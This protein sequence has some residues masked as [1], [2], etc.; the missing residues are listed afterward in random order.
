[1]AAQGVRGGRLVV[2]GGELLVALQ[3]LMYIV[4]V[5]RAGVG[6]LD[7]QPVFRENALEGLTFLQDFVK[8]L[9]KGVV[10]LHADV[11]A[12]SQNTSQLSHDLV[13]GMERIPYIGLGIVDKQVVHDA[14]IAGEV[15]K[16]RGDGRHLVRVGGVGRVED[17]GR[18]FH[19]VFIIRDIAD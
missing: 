6:D 8:V 2:P 13:A 12:G 9:L 10:E 3:Q 4:G 1:V 19:S 16:Q 5:D 17:T 18:P 7:H 11:T 15:C 14:G